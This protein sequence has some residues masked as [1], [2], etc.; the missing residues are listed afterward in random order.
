MLPSM[1]PTRPW[2]QTLLLTA[3]AL[4]IAAATI[5]LACGPAAPPIPEE[6]DTF[7]AAPQV[8]GGSEEPEEE[9][10]AT[11]TPTNNYPKLDASLQDVVRKFESGDLTECQAAAQDLAHHA[12]SVLVEVE[13]PTNIDA[14]DTWMANQGIS[15]RHKDATWD[16]PHIYAYVPVSLLGALSQQDG[17]S[18]IRM[19]SGIF[20]DSRDFNERSSCGSEASGA[21]GAGGTSGAS[22]ASETA[23]PQLP[24][25]LKGVHPY[26]RL[27][28]GS[29]LGDVVYRYEQGEIT[30]AEAAA[31]MGVS[32]GTS[33][34]VDVEIE[35]PDNAEAIATWLRDN[36]ASLG[37]VIKDDRG[38]TNYITGSVP[39][40]ILGELSNRPGVLVVYA[41]VSTWPPGPQGAVLDVPLKSPTPTPQGFAAHNVTPW[42]T[43]GYTGSG[44]K[45]GIIDSSFDGFSTLQGSELPAN[46]PASKQ[47]LRCYTAD[48]DL[49]PSANLADC[50]ENDSRDTYH[51][52]EVAQAVID[53]APG[54]ELYIS[55]AAIGVNRVGGRYRLW[56]DVDWMISQGV[57]VINYSQGWDLAQGLGDGIPRNTRW[58][59]N[60]RNS[61]DPLDT[62][63]TAVDAGVI[64]VNAAGNE[65][66]RI[67]Y[68]AFSDGNSDGYHDYATSDD[69]NYITFSGAEREVV[70]ELRWDDSWGNADC[71]V[72]LYLFEEGISAPVKISVATQG[73]NT[74]YSNEKIEHTA[75]LSGRYY[76]KV[77]KRR[78]DDSS[79]LSWFQLYVHSPHTLEHAATGGSISYPA[80]SSSSGMLAV[81]AA[82]WSN[83]SSIQPSSSRGPTTDGRIKPELVGADCATAVTM[84]TSTGVTRESF[85]GTSQ[86]APHVAG[87]AALVKGR[88]PHYTPYDVATYLEENAE[89]RISSPDP[90]NTWGH[91][92]AKLPAS[93][94]AASF[95]TKPA[96]IQVGQSLSFTLDTTQARANITVNN[97]G[98]T[99]KLYIGNSCPTPATNISGFGRWVSDNASVTLTGCSKGTV[100][101]RLYEV[102]GTQKLLNIYRVTVSEAASLSGLTISPGSLVETFTSSG[103]RYT[104]RVDNNISR[105]TVTPTTTTPGAT[106]K[107]NGNST[108]RV[109]ALNVGSNAIRIEVSA[110]GYTTRIYTITVTRAR[111][112]P[113]A[114]LSALTLSEG[115]LA[116][117]FDSGTTAYTAQVDNNISS[118]TVTPTTTT[119]GATIRVG[120]STVS[121]G[122][123]SGAVSL[124]AG[125]KNRITITVSATGY[126]T[127]TYTITVTRAAAPLRPPTNLR[128]STVSGQNRQLQLTYARSPE[129]IHN[130]EFE[131]HYLNKLT[132]KYVNYQRKLDSQSPETFRSVG[133][134]YWYKVQGRNCRDTSQEDTCGVWSDWST[135]VEFSDPGIAISGLTGSYIAGDTDAFSVTLSDLTLDQ[136][137]TVTL[138]S[139]QGS[140]IGFNFQCSYLPSK[141]FT[142]VQS[143]RAKTL[144]FTLHACQIP[145]TTV[146][147]QSG[148]VTAKLWKGSASASG[149]ELDTATANAT[150]TKATG[151]LSPRPSAIT[152][153]HDQT[154]TL[155]TNVPNSVG[156]YITATLS[157]DVGRTALPPTESCLYASSGHAAVNGNTITLRGCR[158]GKTTL[159][160]YRSNS[161]IQ[162][163]SYKVTVNASDTELSPRPSAI[164]A[165]QDLT[166]TLSTGVPNDPG[167]WIT[168]TVPGNAGR[169]TLPPTRGCLYAS[170]SLAA[171]NG[172]T[173]TLRGCQEG[174][175]TLTIYRSNSSVLLAS[176]TVNVAA[177]NTSL[178]PPPAAFT[179]GTNQTFT[180]TTDIANTPGVWVG[181][182]YNSADT[183]RLVLSS[184][185]CTVDSAGT[186]AVSGNSITL[187]P[188][189]AGTVTIMVNRSNS[190]VTL[191]SYPVTINSS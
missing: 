150:V 96:A 160:I 155:T 56:K 38:G 191:V 64:W 110:T 36:G 134:G 189:R 139:N 121:G 131:L 123:A 183:G 164:T 4:L 65:N 23:E 158:E 99:G 169:T 55:N 1:L 106:I 13:L 122:S 146:T 22:G 163:A 188:C 166:F 12:S 58:F 145:G 73:V 29:K 44:I 177:S 70:V 175:T 3:L 90:N 184:Q 83:T 180:L 142:P 187:K 31:E 124:I 190:S 54:A 85:C 46:P 105:I 78:C 11:P 30:A 79:D 111:P 147:A 53:I 161:I 10:T 173:I 52:T 89:Q 120:T 185:D 138:A 21:T 34:D 98:D 87:L 101:I 68:G 157:G 24:L 63:K 20:T 172:N 93:S 47:W 170:S 28:T 179:I 167:V 81:G 119:P 39:L 62:I 136:T 57:D 181:L 115:T 45:V 75:T 126:T 125:S 143:T 41:P 129:T 132:G 135:E 49:T 92:F 6:G 33:V 186:A 84:V 168:A 112:A 95:T 149:S 141:S 114:S 148:T 144:S 182:N 152:V 82:R 48:S 88:F 76:L 165:G 26:P 113:V 43:A 176:Y 102:G 171:V 15:P 117:V 16:P 140:V 32:G 50:A 17:V 71:D 2:P 18:L 107:V 8:E 80:D 19:S 42:H 154:F 156:V 66:R 37:L 130:Y 159:T 162:L 109:V 94:L 61:V 116:P 67:W 9:P 118:V 151:G 91:G 100:T 60:T 74:K 5:M 59:G 133:R 86:A 97:S 108:N 25:W 69:A 72:D 137:Y 178:S 127:R 7:T 51:G 128:L 27:G 153:G 103:T 104:A 14:V 40:S 35:D 77:R 174:A